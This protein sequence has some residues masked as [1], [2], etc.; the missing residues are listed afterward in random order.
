VRALTDQRRHAQQRE[1]ARVR[2]KRQVRSW[3]ATLRLLNRP[4]VLPDDCDAEA[5]E[6]FDHV[7]SYI[8]AYTRPTGTAQEREEELREVQAIV[9]DALLRWL[10]DSEVW[11][12]LEDMREARKHNT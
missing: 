2:L 6:L 12:W 11:S 9:F 1:R 5:E 3:H 10:L 4:T 8:E 7:E